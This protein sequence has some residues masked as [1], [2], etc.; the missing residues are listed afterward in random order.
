MA[1]TA[2]VSSSPGDWP[3]GHFLP[4]SNA[5]LFTTAAALHY[6]GDDYR[7]L[8]VLFADGPVRSGELFGDLVLY[9]TG[10]P[11]FALDTA[12][13]APFADSVMRA[14]IRRGQPGDGQRGR[15]N[16]FLHDLCSLLWSCP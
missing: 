3:N 9:G 12:S 15:Q 11:T 16:P 2:S 4:A 1:T 8:T 14:G 6:L 10:D 13:L 7:F 5:K